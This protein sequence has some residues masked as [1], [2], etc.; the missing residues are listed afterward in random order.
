LQTAEFIAWL[1]KRVGGNLFST[2]DLIDATN[3]AQNRLLGRD[4]GVMRLRPDA[5]LRTTAGT[6]EYTAYSAVYDGLANTTTNYDI[7]AIR[8]VYTYN[9]RGSNQFAY[10]G[11]SR[12]TYRPER[13]VN[14]SLPDVDASCDFD[15][16]RDPGDNLCKVR[17]WPENDPGTTTAVWRCEAFLWPTQILTVNQNITIP[18]RFRHNLLY[19]EVLQ[20]LEYAEYGK[21]DA[22]DAA[23]EKLQDEFD[24]WAN[25]IPTTSYD[26]TYP[27]EA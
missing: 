10:Q 22:P 13:I 26:R 2:Q 1:G 9:I 12:T 15:D 25:G 14:P 3:R 20:E 6:Y 8:R 21:S 4:I 27:R 16:S 18:L 5:W 19:K 23:V 7:R 24:T 17:F 11:L